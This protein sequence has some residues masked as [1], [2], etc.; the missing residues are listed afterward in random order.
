VSA[1]LQLTDILDVR[2]YE[3]V[4]HEYRRKVMA[5]KAC[6]RVALGPIMTIVF[7]C[8]ET[9]RFQV[10]EMARVEGIVTDEGLQAELDVYNHLIPRP[11][12]LSATLFIELVTP[13]DLRRWLPALVGVERAIRFSLSTVGS[14]EGAVEV[15]SEPEAEHA[16]ALT[17]EA[18]TSAVHYLR[19][20]FPPTAVA[21]AR[22]GP[23]ILEVD[24]PEYTARVE[25]AISTVEQLR[26]D[27]AGRPT[28]LD[29]DK[30]PGQGLF[31]S[32]TTP[33]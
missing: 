4:R 25:L 16:A 9:V 13:E 15:R 23:V 3:R 29:V 31:G 30:V 14:S 26:Q 22:S 19:F 1:D 33:E 21:A 17:R 20:R 6:R 5:L 18:A 2:A 12:E 28:R 27:L 7:E 10:Q 32:P 24:H 8:F 11:G